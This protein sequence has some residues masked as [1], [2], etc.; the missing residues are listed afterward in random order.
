MWFV[1]ESDFVGDEGGE[2]LDEG[3]V[4]FVEV[5][6]LGLG[7]EDIFVGLG[8]DV[9]SLCDVGGFVGYDEE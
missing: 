7:V 3:V 5:W 8:G 2:C 9:G 4:V 1:G 6:I